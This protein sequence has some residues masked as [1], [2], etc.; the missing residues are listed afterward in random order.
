MWK[1]RGGCKR[2]PLHT[3]KIKQSHVIGT[4]VTT[5]YALTTAH[6]PQHSTVQELLEETEKNNTIKLNQKDNIIYLRKI[7]RCQRQ[8]ET[9]IGATR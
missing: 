9:A 1:S 3:Q 6:A 7:E 8:P 4:H 2:H 5:T